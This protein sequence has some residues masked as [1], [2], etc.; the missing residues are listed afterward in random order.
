MYGRSV[1][2]VPSH[3]RVIDAHRPAGEGA[4]GPGGPHAAP[5]ARAFAWFVNE[6]E[7]RSSP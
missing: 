1:N 3:E 7:A 2:P 4:G 5:A 6:D